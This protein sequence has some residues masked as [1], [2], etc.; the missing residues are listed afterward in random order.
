MTVKKTKELLKV[1]KNTHVTLKNQWTHK[2]NRFLNFF[3]EYVFN[4]FTIL[5]TIR[6][7]QNL[8]RIKAIM[9]NKKQQKIE[10]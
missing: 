1:T 6:V 2:T 8:C 5:L 9:S 4:K 3:S 7:V 10:K